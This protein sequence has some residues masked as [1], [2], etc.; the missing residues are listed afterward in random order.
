[1]WPQEGTQEWHKKTKFTTFTGPRDTECAPGGSHR[2]GRG[3]GGECQG[4]GLTKQ[5]RGPGADVFTEGQG[6]GHKERHEEVSLMLL[7]HGQGRVERGPYGQEESFL[8]HWDSCH[9]GRGHT[10]SFWG[11]FQGKNKKLQKFIV[12]CNTPK[13]QENS[14][15]P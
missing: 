9:L 14:I 8:T 6:R 13:N 10:A 15:I 3:W 12:H 11:C 1:M 2:A 4:S 7:S 5:S